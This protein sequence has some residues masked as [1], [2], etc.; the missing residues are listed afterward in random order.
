M[1][2]AIKLVLLWNLPEDDVLSIDFSQEIPSFSLVL[3]L[4]ITG[5]SCFNAYPFFYK[6][7]ANL[8]ISSFFLALLIFFFSELYPPSGPENPYQQLFYWG[9]AFLLLTSWGWVIIFWASWESAGKLLI[10][11]CIVS[12]SDW[13]V[14][15]CVI[16]LKC[17]SKS[18]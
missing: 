14:V 11:C 16:W 5:S 1:K 12:V 9:L 17:C 4:Y 15:L 3:H 10:I 6:L 7:T 8:L 2:V 13:C 18:R